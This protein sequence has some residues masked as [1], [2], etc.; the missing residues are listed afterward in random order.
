MKILNL[1]AGIG[2]N[3]E[4]LGDE[5]EITAIEYDDEIA[6]IYKER[7]PHHRVIVDCARVQMIHN[8]SEY[9][10][11][12]ASP[13]CP[14][15]S[16]A[17]YWGWS[18]KAP[19]LPDMQ[20]WQVIIFLKHHFD[21]KW[22]VE[23]VNPYYEPLI[24]PTAKIGRHLFWANFRIPYLEHKSSDIRKLSGTSFKDKLDTWSIR[25]AI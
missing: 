10:I 24:Q 25:V 8:F 20:L 21:G 5:H 11:I 18:K 23:N 13:P 15:H 17:R 4:M 2:G 1:Y 6:H 14:T 16:R 9:D 12:W 7:F 22:V 19:V 3:V